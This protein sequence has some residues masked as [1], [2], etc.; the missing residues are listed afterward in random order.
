M[1]LRRTDQPRLTWYLVE[2]KSFAAGPIIIV[3]AGARGGAEPHWYHYGSQAKVFGFDPDPTETDRLNGRSSGTPQTYIPIALSESDGTRI[4]YDRPFAPASGFFK[5]NVGFVRRLVDFPNLDG[6]RPLEVHVAKL[7]TLVQKGEIQTPD[8]VKLDVQ[9][10]ELSVLRGAA[11]SLRSSVLGVSVEVAFDKLY[12]DAPT[13]GEVSSY[14]K[15]FG[16]YLYDLVPSRMARNIF[17][18]QYPGAIN[19]GQV[20]WG[21]ALFLRDG[22]GEIEE[23]TPLRIEGVWSEARVLK[24][25]SLMEL[26][27]LPDCA[28][29]LIRFAWKRNIVQG[30]DAQRMLGLLA[31]G[32]EYRTLYGGSAQSGIGSLF[33][34]LPAPVR[35][36][37]RAGAL[38]VRNLADAL[39]GL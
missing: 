10:G 34:V 2:R 33:R 35:N 27:G 5:Y 25:A 13:F 19:T 20:I 12:E 37:A 15:A 22:V 16:L 17:T 32:M 36:A 9:G 1:S 14:L 30:R 4:F 18:N 39:L 31:A 26:F 28:A 3:D 23:D 24:S 8:F 7:D 21:Q 11:R 29:E 38:T 6:G